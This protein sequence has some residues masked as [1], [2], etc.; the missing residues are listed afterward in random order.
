MI[1]ELIRLYFYCHFQLQRK[2]VKN[3]DKKIVTDDGY[4]ITGFTGRTIINYKQLKFE[5]F[6]NIYKTKHVN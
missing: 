4:N 1:N 3:R 6:K 5:P 2:I